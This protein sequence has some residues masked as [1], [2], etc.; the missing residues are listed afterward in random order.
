MS[1]SCLVSERSNIPFFTGKYGHPLL[2][3]CGSLIGD[4][5]LHKLSSKGINVVA[6]TV[7]QTHVHEQLEQRLHEIVS[8]NSGFPE[9]VVYFSPS[10]LNFTIPML[11][12]MQ[13]PLQQLKVYIIL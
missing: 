1:M 8:H 13:V 7:Y 4:E 3:P 11:E 12:K 10:G 9:I 2:F 6:V 5:L